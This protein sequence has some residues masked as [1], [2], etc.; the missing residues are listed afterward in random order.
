M[1][2]S[3]NKTANLD[4]FEAL[5][6]LSTDWLNRDASIRTAYYIKRNAQL[7]E[8]D[9]LRS[10]NENAVNTPF[11]NTIKKV[12][13]QKFPDIIA[14]NYFGVEVK[15]SK[16][17]KWATIGGSVNESTRVEGIE[18]IFLT[19]G[20]LISPVEFRTR[21]YEDCL[22]GIA[23]THYPRYKIDMTLQ[24]GE[25]IFDLMDITYDELRHSND[26]VGT[27][28]RYY[29]SQ[30][31]EGERLWWAGGADMEEVIEVDELKIRLANTLTAQERQI[32]T[33]EG[34]A[35]FPEIFGKKQ[36]KYSQFALWMAAEHRAV[37]TSM[38]DFFSAG[39]QFPI[40]TDYETFEKM[41][42]M[43]VKIDEFKEKIRQI[44]EFT[45][46]VTLCR[47]WRV[48]KIYNDRIGQWIYE[49][50]RHSENFGNYSSKEVLDAIFKR[51]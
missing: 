32:I 16:D 29:K 42:Q 20:K 24:Q 47:T 33:A 1:I 50:G 45:S 21:P 41:P 14:D 22:S 28:V 46:E 35:L 31:K 44:I 49:I 10:L 51:I 7:L 34:L 15:S 18:R 3:T 9:V 38:R 4:D 30:M 26:P 37:S 23:V 27:V 19:F 13:G 5:T 39:G 48:S 2:I 8:D 43:V 12:S 17:D 6:R 25:T 36:Q 11:V 40:N